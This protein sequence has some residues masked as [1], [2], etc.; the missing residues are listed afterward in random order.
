MSEQEALDFVEGHGVVTESARASVPSLAETVTGGPISGSWW[1]HPCSHEIFRLTRAVRRSPDILVCRLVAGKVTYV[2]RRIWP[3]LVRL[4]SR[5]DRKQL[6]AI[7]EIHTPSGRHV[8]KETPF[9]GWVSDEIVS[10]A[11]ELSEE[12][13]LAV[14]EQVLGTLSDRNKKRAR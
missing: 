2:H 9:P 6:S 14:L 8:V 5:F 1:A 4:A 3:Y 10:K 11:Q 12:E 7:E 13:A